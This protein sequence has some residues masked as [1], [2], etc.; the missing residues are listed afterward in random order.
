LIHTTQLPDLLLTPHE[1]T[2][3]MDHDRPEA[4]SI[5]VFAR[6]VRRP[7]AEAAELPWLVFLQG[8][9]GHESPRPPSREGWIGRAVEDYRVLLLDQRGT[10]LSSPL[11][12]QTLAH[13]SPEEQARTFMNFR[14]D[15]IV[16]DLECIRRELIGDDRWSLL[17]QSYGGFC[18]VHYLSAAPQGLR[19]VMITGGLP[20]TGGDVDD[21]YRTTYPIVA[22][23]NRRYYERYPE[24]ADR[25]RAIMRHLD[26]NRVPWPGGER[27]SPRQLQQLGLGLGMS[28]GAEKIHYLVEQ[29]F[30]SGHAGPEI[31]EA[32]VTGVA[33]ELPFLLHP[34]FSILHEAGYCEGSS[35]RWSAQRLRGD[36]AQFDL[37][38]DGPPHFTGEMIYPWQFEEY[39]QLAPF[40]E[41][42]EI[43]ADYD[44]WPALYDLEQL[45]ANEVPCA[46]AIY[47]DDM[48]V[49]PGLSQET[50]A[51][52]QGIEVWLADEYQ[53]DALRVVGEPI[54]DRLMSMLSP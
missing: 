7:E 30:V 32:F 35:S 3:P 6:E 27:L 43:L 5:T 46:A 44:G 20:P 40:R 1:F 38:S 10:G 54:L 11:V 22:E 49:A 42:A 37:S 33:A 14:A 39:E 31:C 48:Y 34:I 23:R 17:G 36:Y 19:Q 45:G 53:H 13:L 15:S 9:P 4:D 16:R 52:I 24:D 25:V 50:A 41:A 8:G 29:A 12:A 2:V 21:V 51:R 18:A 47:P 28:D 26:V